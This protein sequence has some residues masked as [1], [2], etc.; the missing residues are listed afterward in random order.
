MA[1]AA[2]AVIAEEEAKAQAEAEAKQQAGKLRLL[3]FEAA[4]GNVVEGHGWRWSAEQGCWPAP[5][6][7]PLWTAA[8]ADENKSKASINTLK[9]A[10]TSWHHSS[11]TGRLGR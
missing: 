3:E 8:Q 4:G 11:H 9:L 6:A 1:A 7:S 2:A 5:S 10:S